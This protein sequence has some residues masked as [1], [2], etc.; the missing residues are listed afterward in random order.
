MTTSVIEMSRAAIL[1][2]RN[3]DGMRNNLWL[4]LLYP[5]M[6]FLKKK[7]ELIMLHKLCIL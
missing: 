6:I 3:N 7:R 4:V 2:N 5:K 1:G